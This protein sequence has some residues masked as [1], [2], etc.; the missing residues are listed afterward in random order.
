MARV[1]VTPAQAAYL[2]QQV[3]AVR[4]A[5]QALQQALALLT[6]GAE[7]PEGAILSDINVDTGV[8]TFTVPEL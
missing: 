4:A 2:A 7:L 3:S 6:L 5:E 8:L 1:I